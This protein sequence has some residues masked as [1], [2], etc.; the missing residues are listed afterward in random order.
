[1]PT[2]TRTHNGFYLE[3]ESTR[4]WRRITVAPAPITPL[5]RD[6]TITQWSDNGQFADSPVIDWS[7]GGRE[8]IADARR[9]A[10]V[11]ELA[12]AIAADIETWVQ[13]ADIE[14][15]IAEG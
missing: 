6:V 11:I 1:M 4:L 3:I 15:C 9:F 2:I 14:T 10:Q 7:S 13:A 12:A 8:S 5:S